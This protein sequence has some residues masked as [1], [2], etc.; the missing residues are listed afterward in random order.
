VVA[1]GLL[2]LLAAGGA[3]A[4]ERTVQAQGVAGIAKGERLGAARQRAVSSGIAQAVYEVV[5]E[6]LPALPPDEAA[7][8]GPR[9]FGS[10]A[11]DYVTRFRVVE[12]RGA[13]PREYSPDPDVTHEYVVV[14]E[15]TVDA[16]AVRARLAEAGL[17]APAG[18]GAARRVSLTLEDLPDYA[19]YEAIRE[20][21]VDRLQAESAAPLEFSRRRAVLDVVTHE[22]ARQLL[23][24]LSALS[25]P[26][27][28][29]E[30]AAAD[31]RSALARVRAEEPAAGE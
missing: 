6:A 22:D 31:E 26:G 21:L 10:D 12:D 27:I 19:A 7:D 4:E 30:P 23:A 25:L 9:L 28:R 8:T 5:G 14:V 3:R 11:R 2:L 24:R 29:I 1:A 16:R 13:Q 17:L 15:A 18:E 20:A